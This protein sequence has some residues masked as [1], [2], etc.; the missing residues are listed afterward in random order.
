M[1]EQ[2]LNVLGLQIIWKAHGLTSEAELLSEGTV[3]RDKLKEQRESLLEKLT[4]YAVGTQSN[5]VEGVKRA[6][7]TV[8][9][10]YLRYS[11]VF[12][13]RLFK[14]SWPYRYFFAQNGLLMDLYHLRRWLS[15]LMMKFSIGVQ[16]ISRLKSNAMRKTSMAASVILLTAMMD[17]A[18]RMMKRQRT[19]PRRARRGRL[20]KER[21]L[22]RE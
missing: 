13:F 12:Y 9:L 7:S 22:I 3:F 18:V 11:D 4:E 1:V 21:K 15:P 5:T 8:F 14:L 17:G 2:A 20:G 10:Y 19:N 16:V 6:V